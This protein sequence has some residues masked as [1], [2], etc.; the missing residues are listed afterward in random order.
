MQNSS[1]ISF[2]RRI[3]GKDFNPIKIHREFRRLVDKSDYVESE[4]PAILEHF[5]QL[6][7]SSK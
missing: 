1:F 2:G 5:K 6:T 7:K 4:V 3:K